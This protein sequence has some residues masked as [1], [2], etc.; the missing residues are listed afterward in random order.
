VGC[1]RRQPVAPRPLQIGRTATR[2]RRASAV[3]GDVRVRGFGDG[4]RVIT[5]NLQIFG[6]TYR[7]GSSA[8]R[9]STIRRQV[10]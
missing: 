7:C 2:S 1:A 9:Y 6:Y 5:P 4:R 3:T 8:H 10:P